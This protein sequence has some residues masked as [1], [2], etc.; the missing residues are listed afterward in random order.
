MYLSPYS[1]FSSSHLGIELIM[2]LAPSNKVVQSGNAM[3]HEPPVFIEGTKFAEEGSVGEYEIQESRQKITKP[4]PYSLLGRL[5]SD[6]GFRQA[7]VSR[8]SRIGY[9]FA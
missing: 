6:S 5:V 3:R 9:I 1:L 2:H 7:V 4:G 8:R